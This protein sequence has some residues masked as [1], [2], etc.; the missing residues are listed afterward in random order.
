MTSPGG[1]DGWR[2]LRSDGE[3]HSRLAF[4]QVHPDETEFSAE[5][6]LRAA[7][8][9]FASMGVQ[10]QRVLTDNGM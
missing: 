5:A 9:Y 4:T 2:S 10:I 6:F 1:I 7:V 8:G 3:D